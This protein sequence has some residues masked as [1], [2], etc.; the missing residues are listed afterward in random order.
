QE[1]DESKTE[2]V[3][4]LDTKETIRQY[5]DIIMEISDDIIELTEEI[6]EVIKNGTKKTINDKIHIT[7]TDHISNLLERMAL[8]IIFDSSL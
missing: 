1:A 8:G 7:L 5:Q 2:K 4:T 3:F 6:I